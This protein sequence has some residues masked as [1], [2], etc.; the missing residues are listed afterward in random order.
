MGGLGLVPGVGSKRVYLVT[1]GPEARG[2]GGEGEMTD[3]VGWCTETGCPGAAALR[4]SPCCKR[5]P[6][7]LLEWE[8]LFPVTVHIMRTPVQRRGP[9]NSWEDQKLKQGCETQYLPC[10]HDHL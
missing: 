5:P 8:C 4:N 2:E 7:S 1:Q 6:Q 10:S 9:S 3:I